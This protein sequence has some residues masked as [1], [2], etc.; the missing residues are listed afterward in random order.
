MKGKLATRGLRLA[1]AGLLG[2][3]LTGCSTTLPYHQPEGLNAN[4]DGALVVAAVVRRGRAQSPGPQIDVYSF[5]AGCPD[6]TS[7]L[8]ARG[9]RG[10][11]TPDP[12]RTTT[13]VLPGDEAVLLKAH[14]SDGSQFCSSAL[15]FR[16][17]AR[18][19]YLYSYA[20][21]ARGNGACRIFLNEVVSS[22]GT[23]IETRPV[24]SLRGFLVDVDFWS[25]E[26][27]EK[28]VCGLAS[29]P[30]DNPRSLDA[31]AAL[32]PT[33]PAGMAEAP[34]KA[35]DGLLSPPAVGAEITALAQSLPARIPP[36]VTEP[37]RI[38]R[39]SGHSIAARVGFTAGGDTIATAR[40]SNGSER[41]VAGG[42]GGLVALEARVTPL[43]WRDTVGLGVG[44]ELGWKGQEISASNGSI[45]LSRFP[46]LATAHLVAR[47]GERSY[48]QLTGGVEKDLAVSLTG[49][50]DGSVGGIEVEGAWGGTGSLA[51]AYAFTPHF[52]FD[53][54]VRVA[55]LNYTARD[56]TGASARLSASYGGFSFGL[57]Y[58]F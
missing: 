26:E 17:R 32:P 3:D 43:W 14:W 35:E 53:G 29:I 37:S 15:A 11:V 51:Y 21:P 41:Q 7:R 49:T 57:Q 19:T 12:A 54:T 25:D 36:A 28:D 23:K 34:P 50:G 42:G 4:T 1:V 22:P 38:P 44:A 47:V 13:F 5:S 24:Q 16:P 9:Y 18:A 58:H 52:L 55:G 45:S 48:V 10:S 33:E 39:I 20:A 40:S 46:F 30:A 8:S 27:P 56:T 31:T 6:L 2:S